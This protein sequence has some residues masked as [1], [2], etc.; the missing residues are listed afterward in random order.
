RFR[1]RWTENAE[2]GAPARL[3]SAPNRASNTWLIDYQPIVEQTLVDLFD[4]VEK[5]REPAGSSFE[6]HDGKVTLPPSAAERGG[7]Q[8]VVTVRA[9][10]SLA[11]EVRVG[12]PV[13]L[14]VH[15][16]V[17]PGAGT[18]VA[19]DWDFDGT[20]T[21]GF[22]HEAIDG[23]AEKI[24]LSTTHQFDRPGVYFVTALVHSH[25]DGDVAATF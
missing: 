24:D 8:P 11:A 12:E 5:G 16:E 23:T 1:L 22:H 25:R 10:D 4:W 2:H 14:S 17:P 19:V 6:Y 7:I 9:N 15:A 18:I 13:T 20:G 21:Y 3:A